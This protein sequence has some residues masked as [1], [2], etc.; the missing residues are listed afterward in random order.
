MERLD[1][2]FWNERY[3]SG[4]MG[5]D[6]GYAAPALTEY[7]DQLEDKTMQ[8]LIPGAGNA[9][10]AEYL[11]Q[12]GFESVIVL[13]WAEEA[14]AHFKQR[15]PEFPE[16]HLICENFF[17]FRG[18]FDLILEQTFFCA[19]DPRL[20]SK[21]AKHVHEL[22]KPGGRLVGVMFNISLYDDHPPFGGGKSDYLPIFEP[23]FEIEAMEECYNS[24]PPRAGNE[25]FVNLKRKTT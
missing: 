3:R 6:I 8:I 15:V 23:W 11:H 14:I 21:Y 19:L 13:D 18:S 2:E 7:A 16:D 25:L 20:R 9:Y 1:P 10:E 4:N 24:I 22:L 17:D 12:H 5:W